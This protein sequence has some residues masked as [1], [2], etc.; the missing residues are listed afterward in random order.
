MHFTL[1]LHFG[2]AKCMV[3]HDRNSFQLYVVLWLSLWSLEEMQSDQFN[4]D[5]FF[6]CLGKSD[7]SS[8]EWR[9]LDKS[10]YTSYQ[11]N[12]VML[13]WSPCMHRRV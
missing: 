10:L 11:K 6:M 9:T 4:M 2:N 13:N 8:V 12:T 1:S 7:L 5:V 3:Q